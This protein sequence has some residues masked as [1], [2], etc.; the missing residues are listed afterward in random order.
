MD[1]GLEKLLE[2]TPREDHC[3]FYIDPHV[4]ADLLLLGCPGVAAC[5][6]TESLE[7][8][9]IASPLIAGTNLSTYLSIYIFIY[10]PPLSL[11]LLSNFISFL[12]LFVC[13]SIC[14]IICLFVYVS[15]GNSGKG[16][17]CVSPCVAM[18]CGLHYHLWVNQHPPDFAPTMSCS[19]M[20]M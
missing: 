16:F 19:T 9:M 6:V 14:R 12:C 1:A 11:C 3:W 4:S 17:M 20:C 8:S 13:L 7:V 5:S 10:P 2:V 15:R 18:G